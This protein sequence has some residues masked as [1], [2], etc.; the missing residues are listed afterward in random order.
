MTHSIDKSPS[1]IFR[2]NGVPLWIK[3]PYTL[4]AMVILPVYWYQYGV[5][6]FLW[7]S[8]IAFF[9][10]VP[11]LWFKNRLI[12]SMMAIGVLPLE[13]LWLAG[14]LSGGAFLGIAAYMFD[15]SLPLW[16]RLLSLFHFP[17]P[18]VIL[19]M[20]FRFGYDARA[21]YPQ[22]ALSALVI[23]MTHV[24]APREENINLIYPPEGL[25]DIMPEAAYVVL[26]PLVLIGCVIVPMHYFLKG[27]FNKTVTPSWRPGRV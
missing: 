5:T 3:L 24:F 18:A 4:L 22:I 16:L 7:F 2:D 20:L 12:T 11:A 23:L 27:R 19:Y 21:L 10:M 13:L 25:K 17:M 1:G 15:P 8:D 26:M 14:L 6:N 9:A